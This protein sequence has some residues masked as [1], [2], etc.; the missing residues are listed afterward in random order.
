[1]ATF[2][3]TVEP[4]LAR[5]DRY[6]EIGTVQARLYPQLR[7]VFEEIARLSTPAERRGGDRQPA[8]TG[9]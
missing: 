5:Y 3:Q 2:G 6:R 1:M 8:E 7:E 4:D 9:A